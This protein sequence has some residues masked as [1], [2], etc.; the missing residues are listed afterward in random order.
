MAQFRVKPFSVFVNGKKVGQFETTTFTYNSGDEA[1]FGDVPG[2][3][4]GYSDGA[5]TC[6]LKA[7]SFVPA[8]GMD[9][10]FMTAMDNK[11]DLDITVSPVNAKIRQV[12]MRCTEAQYTSTMKT[13]TQEGDFTLGGGTPKDVGTA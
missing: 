8:A 9:F 13:G 2:G 12:T 10:D 1:L 6:T 3:F 4:G 11:Q 7:K 5:G